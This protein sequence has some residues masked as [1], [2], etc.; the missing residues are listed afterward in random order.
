MTKRQALRDTAVGRYLLKIEKAPALLELDARQSKKFSALVEQL[1]A[2]RQDIQK[3][4]AAAFTEKRGNPEHATAILKDGTP[5][6]K[7]E[8][9]KKIG[10]IRQE[11]E[12]EIAAKA[13]DAIAEFE[14]GAQEILKEDQQA[15]L[16]KLV[17]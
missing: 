11:L 1:N 12:A 2:R 10:L 8:L 3:S 6:Q 16:K 15:Q 13:N 14:K 4:Y 9:T 5:E 17:E 7:A